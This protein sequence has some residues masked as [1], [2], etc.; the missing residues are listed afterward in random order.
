MKRPPKSHEKNGNSQSHSTIRHKLPVKAHTWLRESNE[1]I[2]SPN[3]VAVRLKEKANNHSWGQSIVCNLQNGAQ[4]HRGCFRNSLLVDWYLLSLRH[5][6]LVLQLQWLS[7]NHQSLLG[8][9]PPNLSP[10]IQ[11][12]VFRN[13]WYVQILPFEFFLMML[14]D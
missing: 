10:A 7:R 1:A 13:H 5:G 4:P 6:W 3:A 8:R 14:R 11:L 2:D 9:Y 12:T